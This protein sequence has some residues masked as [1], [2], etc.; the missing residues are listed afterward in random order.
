MRAFNN[1][2]VQAQFLTESPNSF[3]SIFLVVSMMLSL[4]F[5]PKLS[6]NL[7]SIELRLMVLKHVCDDQGDSVLITMADRPSA[8]Y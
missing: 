1:L 4:I 7:F 3:D 5:F 6:V 2:L 8:P